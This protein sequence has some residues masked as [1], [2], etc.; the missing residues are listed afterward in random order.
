MTYNK[1]STDFGARVRY[2]RNIA[3]LSQEKLAEEM[4]WRFMLVNQR[5][6]SKRNL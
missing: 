1:F 2:Y 5:I 3:R 6:L 4:G